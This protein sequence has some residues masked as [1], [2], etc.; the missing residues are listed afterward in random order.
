MVQIRID[1]FSMIYLGYTI[2]YEPFSKW[3]PLKND[4]N[5]KRLIY[6]IAIIEEF[7]AL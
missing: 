1:V 5:N 4:E 2:L 3:P 6:R 7:S